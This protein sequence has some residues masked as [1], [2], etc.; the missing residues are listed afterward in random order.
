M[1]LR[2]LDILNIINEGVHDPGIFKAIFLAGGPGSGKSFVGS[3]LIGLPSK[4]GFSGINMSF[5]PNGLK[6][7]NSDTEFEY[8]LKK[9]G[10][11]PNLTKLS[12]DEF[13]KVTT[14][15]ES[16]RAKAKGISKKR[17]QLYI[18]GRLGLLIDGTGHDYD[19]IKEQR[20]KLSILGYD[21]Y[22]IFVNTSLEVALERNSQRDRVVPEKIV[23]DSWNATQQNLGK[24]QSLFKGNIRIVDNTEK[25]LPKRG[26]RMFPKTLYTAIRT[27][28]E[29]PVENNAAKRWIAQQGGKQ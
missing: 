3:E 16:I 22:M 2:L 28:V 18:Q 27:F 9:S 15:P 5:A 23:K 11:D 14:G 6:A 7:V 1:K 24:F 8:F 20:K 12:D 10:I 21:T 26:E 13:K 29:S 19:K 25:K 4:G 17:E